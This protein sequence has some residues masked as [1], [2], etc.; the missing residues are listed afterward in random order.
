MSADEQGQNA[1]RETHFVCELVKFFNDHLVIVL[2]GLGQ[3]Q[4]TRVRLR[5]PSHQNRCDDKRNSCGHK[6]KARFV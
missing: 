4:K 3:R 6:K 5:R 2:R 1:I